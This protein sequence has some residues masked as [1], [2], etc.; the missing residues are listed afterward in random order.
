[1]TDGNEV[2]G[3]SSLRPAWAH[4]MAAVSRFGEDAGV[5]PS[6]EEPITL[7]EMNVYIHGRMT[8]LTTTQLFLFFRI[9]S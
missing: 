5:I 7:L 2:V 3:P 9:M 4:D 6:E 8:R 1:M